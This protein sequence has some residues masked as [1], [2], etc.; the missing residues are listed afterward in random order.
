MDAVAVPVAVV[1]PEAVIVTDAVWVAVS[2]WVAVWV[3]GGSAD[4]LTEA[5]SFP[6]VISTPQTSGSDRVA[7]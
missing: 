2:V 3:G 6:T 4:G 5:A 1:V 7:E